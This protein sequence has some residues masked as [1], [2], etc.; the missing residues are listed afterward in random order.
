ML[1]FAFLQSVPV[2]F[3]Y[4]FL[5]TAFGILLEKAGFNFIWAF[6]ASL[7]VYAGSLQF[8]IVSFLSAG[9]ALTTVALMSLFINSRHIFYGLSFIENF[10]KT[11]KA[12]PYMVFS[13]TDET[14][15]ILCS[16]QVPD[17]MNY[18]T[19]IFLIALLNQCYWIIGSVLG[20]LVGQM[21]PF[22]VTGIDF[23]M[24]ALFVVIFLEQWKTS[25]T[26]LP[27]LTG[28]TCSILFLL[29]LGPDRFLLPSLVATVLLLSVCKP[30][31]KIKEEK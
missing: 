29:L 16:L 19:V 12:Y 14:Y 3:G 26:H 7:T 9:T 8:V 17:G 13:L 4:L 10:K 5:G 23:S 18:N 28:F 27:A 6:F 20:G 15:S 22:D 25:E 21:I 24:T 30:F 2:M 1:R 11:G 31:I